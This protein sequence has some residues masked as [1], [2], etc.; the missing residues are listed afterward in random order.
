MAAASRKTQLL[1]SIE[2]RRLADN[3]EVVGRRRGPE[4]LGLYRKR[5]ARKGSYD[6]D[7]LG[8]FRYS[9]LKEAA[10]TANAMGFE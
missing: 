6:F 4:V 2:E 10:G 7:V 8:R 1:R 9:D 5:P 3:P